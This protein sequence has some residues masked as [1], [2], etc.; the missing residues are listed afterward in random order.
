MSYSQPDP[1]EETTQ[2]ETPE[3]PDTDQ[4]NLEEQGGEPAAL[5]IDADDVPTKPAD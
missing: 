1:A 5:E 3:Q 2:S 4:E